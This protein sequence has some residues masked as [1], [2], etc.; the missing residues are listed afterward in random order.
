MG[1]PHRLTQVLNNLLS[2]AIKF[3]EKGHVRLKVSCRPGKPVTVDV[4]DTGVGMTEA[5]LSR[6]FES[7]EQAD[8]SMTRRFGGTGLGL[9]IVR[10]L[11]LLMGGM[12]TINSA[13]NQGTSVRVILPLPE[14]PN[15]QVT[16]SETDDTTDRISLSGRKI[17]I[18][19]DNSTNRLVLSEMLGPTGVDLT[20]VENGQDAVDRWSRARS[21]GKPFDLL[22]LDITMP[23]LDGMG[24]LSEIR[25]MEQKAGLSTVPAV[26]VTANAM[27][28]QV[29]DYIMG[30]FDTHLSK[31]F[32]RKELLHALQ[33]LLRG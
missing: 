15:A 22:L 14:A 31:P 23:V 2:N 19:D 25:Q 17:L 28:N 24:A 4:T 20:L 18:A 1:D 21:A 12:I 11:V 30:G 33:T 16:V 27:P 6:V 9:S 8:G 29:A 3:T 13:L 32:K 26:A 5:Q 7:F 10:Q